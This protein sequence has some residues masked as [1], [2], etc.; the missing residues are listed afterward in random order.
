VY[1]DNST[2][3]NTVNAWVSRS[4]TI[5][6]E[7]RRL[8]QLCDRHGL[9]LEMRFLPSALNIYADRLSRRRRVTDYLPRIKEIPESWW[10]GDSELDYKINWSQIDLLRPPLEMLP[11]VPRK[12]EA[13]GFRGMLLVPCWPRQ[14][15]YQQLLEL[16]RSHLVLEPDM[17]FSRMA[18]RATLLALSREAEARASELRLWRT[19]SQSDLSPQYQ[20]SKETSVVWQRGEH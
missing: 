6:P 1:T 17:S 4:P 11:L 7:L 9:Q 18:W 13:D 8:Y 10:S 19:Q 15:W 16:A 5:M 20:R 3:M 12:V 2:F 14:N